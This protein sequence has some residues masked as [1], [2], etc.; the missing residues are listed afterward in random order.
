VTRIK[1]C[2]FT[3]VDD[4]RDAAAAGVDA[5]GMVFWPGS[6]RCVTPEQASAIVASLPPF[7]TTVGVF[8]NESVDTMTGVCRDLGLG[9]VQLHGDEP[10][11]TWSGWPCPVLKS[12]AV[13]PGFD[14]EVLR[15]W[16][17]GVVP[18]LDAADVCRR[19][20]TGRTVDWSLA[21]AAARVRPLVLA[22]GL[23]PET[24]RAAI[25]AVSPAAVDVSSGI[26]VAPGVKDGDRMRA[27]VLAVRR[28][29]EAEGA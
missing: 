15:T 7:V 10:Q 8:V 14:P 9:A 18:L 5:I 13:G 2:G 19:G 21:A 3:R 1:M 4:A 16:P 25:A 28:A 12:V 17:R 24:V 23:T 26:E 11:A 29:D 22:G 20:G 27:F 6:P